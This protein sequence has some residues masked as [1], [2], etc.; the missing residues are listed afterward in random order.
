MGAAMVLG[1]F[2][3][4]WLLRRDHPTPLKVIPYECGEE[5]VGRTWVQFHIGYYVVALVFVVFDVEAVFLVPWAVAFK[6]LGVAG[7]IGMMIFIGILL[8]GLLWVWK[9]GAL[10][11]L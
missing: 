9:K 10:E 4:A 6:E 1:G 7:F 8:L 5:T 2:A 3:A 11:W